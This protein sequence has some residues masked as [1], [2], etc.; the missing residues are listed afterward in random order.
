MK[1]KRSAVFRTCVTGV[2]A[3]ATSLTIGLA[4]ACS[5][6]D[7]TPDDEDTTVARVDEQLVKNGD[8][9]YYSDNKGLYPISN[10]DNWTGGTTGNS[11]ASM[12]GIIDTKKERWDY[13]TNPEFPKT[14]EDNNDLKSDNKDKKDYNGALTDDLPYKDPHAATATDAKDEDKVYINNPFTHEYRYDSEG[15]VLNNK[16]EEVTTLQNLRPY[17]PQL[18]LELLH[19]HGELFQKLHHSHLEGEHGGGNFPLG[20]DLRPV[21]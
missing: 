13:I 2:T 12:S 20:Q 7:T 6:K 19:G 18:P 5:T 17:A 3:V 11:S 9:E 14:L 4:A 8:F 1:K 16:N 10:P 21:F 15:K